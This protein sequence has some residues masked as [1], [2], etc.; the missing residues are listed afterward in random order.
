MTGLGSTRAARARKPDQMAGHSNQ[1]R[2]RVRAHGTQVTTK[3]G[4]GVSRNVLSS[5]LEHTKTAPP[6]DPSRHSCF[7]RCLWPASGSSTLQAPRD[8]ALT[9]KERRFSA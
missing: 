3:L 4:A 5:Q 6:A 8:A 2:V 1:A 7:K 9:P